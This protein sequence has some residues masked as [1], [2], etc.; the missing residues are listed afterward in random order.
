MGGLNKGMTLF[1]FENVWLK[2]EGFG[3]LVKA[4]WQSKEFR[5]NPSFVLEKKLQALKGD[6]KK[7]NREVFS[8][9]SV[10]K[11]HWRK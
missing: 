8:N 5:G 9:M 2:A 6:L 4:W 1:K 3:E 11:E 10:H 7:C